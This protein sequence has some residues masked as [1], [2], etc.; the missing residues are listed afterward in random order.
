MWSAYSVSVGGVEVGVKWS[1]HCRGRHCPYWVL[2]SLS[3]V[4]LRMTEGRYCSFTQDS[5]SRRDW[6]QIF[7]ISTARAKLDHIKPPSQHFTYFDFFCTFSFFNSLI[8]L[9]QRYVG[10]FFFAFLSDLCSP[11][12]VLTSVLISSVVHES[13]PTFPRWLSVTCRRRQG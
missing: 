4:R 7:I 2:L 3:D 5:I 6:Y 13:M 12:L 10:E 1:L 9:S 8:L 11:T